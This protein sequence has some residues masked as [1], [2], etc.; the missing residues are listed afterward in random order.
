MKKLLLIFSII[1]LL[2]IQLIAQSTDSAFHFNRISFD[3]GTFSG[4]TYLTGQP[5]TATK[6]LGANF[7]GL[8]QV[9]FRVTKNFSVSSGVRWNYSANSLKM[10]LTFDPDFF[11]TETQSIQIPLLINYDFYSPKQ[12]NLFGISLGAS[13]NWNTHKTSYNQII[14]RTPSTVPYEQFNTTVYDNDYSLLVNFHKTFSL[15][16]KNKIQLSVFNEYQLNLDI[17]RFR[18]RVE[19]PVYTLA[20]IDDKFVPF[21][22]RLGFQ[23]RFG[24]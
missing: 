23:V 3:I 6:T 10:N 12:K 16:P 14:Y 17:S 20:F 11:V 22:V 9:N 15:H 13:Y 8:A 7:G 4:V 21:F 1:L 5:T 24:L 18:N 19:K 2:S